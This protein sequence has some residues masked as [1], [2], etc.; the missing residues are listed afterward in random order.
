MAYWA[1]VTLCII[2]YVHVV[3]K[4]V[5]RGYS[6]ATHVAGELENSVFPSFVPIKV[7]SRGK[8]LVTR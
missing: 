6:G 3:L 2:V 7:R 8:F 1:H 5:F 4:F